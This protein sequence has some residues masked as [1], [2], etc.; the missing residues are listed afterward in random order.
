[1]GGKNGKK[2]K[3]YMCMYSKN[4]HIHVSTHTNRKKVEKEK[5]TK[6]EKNC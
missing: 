6:S 4:S 5:R 3:K 2:F 1:M